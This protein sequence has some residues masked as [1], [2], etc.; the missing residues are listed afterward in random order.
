MMMM[1]RSQQRVINHQRAA[2]METHH[3]HLMMM[4][5]QVPKSLKCQL[6]KKQIIHHQI[7]MMMEATSLLQIT[8]LIDLRIECIRENNYF[9]DVECQIKKLYIKFKER[10]KL[11]MILVDLKQASMDL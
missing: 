3:H 8:K 9:K 11:L 2:A 7:M 5:H 10:K 1:M 6:T 4:K